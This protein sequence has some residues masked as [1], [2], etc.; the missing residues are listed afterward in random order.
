MFFLQLNSLITLAYQLK[1]FLFIR[2]ANS[3]KSNTKM[4]YGGYEC[5]CNGNFDVYYRDQRF[6]LHF[7]Y[8][9]LQ[10]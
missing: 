9:Y 1:N 8:R 6:G 10:S 2:R 3:E 7:V 4:L 5:S